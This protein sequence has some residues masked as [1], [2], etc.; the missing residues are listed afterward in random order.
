MNALAGLINPQAIGQG[1][2][3]AFEQGRAMRADMESRN[4]LSALVMNP[5][6]QQAMGTLA[7]YNPQAAMQ[8]QARNDQMAQQRA[9]QQAEQRKAE[10]VRRSMSGDQDAMTELATIALDDYVKIDKSMRDKDAQE[11]DTLGQAALQLLNTPPANRNQQLQL[12]AQQMPQYADKIMSVAQM[13][14]QSQEAA[15]QSVVFQAGLTRQMQQMLEP[16]YRTLG[17]GEVLVDTNNPAAV[18]QFAAGGAPQGGQQSAFDQYAQNNGGYRA[19]DFINQKRANPQGA[20]QWAQGK[21]FSVETPDQADMLP[22]G[23]QIRLP[24]GS[25]GRVP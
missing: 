14:P 17:P 22:S 7:Q 25:I 2:L 1:P 24:D 5:G 11:I 19:R 10:L 6:D 18:N 16:N 23:T 12:I 21:V 20:N 9:A 3:Q 4:A 8:M 15:L 13:D